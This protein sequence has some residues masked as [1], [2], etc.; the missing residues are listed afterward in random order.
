MPLAL[1]GDRAVNWTTHPNLYQL[2]H[3]FHWLTYGQ[4][5]AGVQ[6][7]AAVVATLAAIVAG[8]FAARAYFATVKQVRLAKKQLKLAHSQFDIE[9]QRYDEERVAAFHTAQAE[10]ERRVAEEDGLRPRFAMGA[11]WRSGLAILDIKNV[12]ESQALD[13]EFLSGLTKQTL[14][15]AQS[16]APNATVRVQMQEIEL[17]TNGLEVRF[18]TSFGSRWRLL[19]WSASKPDRGTE[20][21]ISVQRIFAPP[22]A[23]PHSP[24][25]PPDPQLSRI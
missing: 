18:R 4:N 21:I 1:D 8:F 19:L 2:A 16:L 17:D 12:G 22:T 13:V 11:S 7:I 25:L 14:S 15:I 20:Q 5:A 10:Y 24:L 6:T 3:P 9:R 23:L